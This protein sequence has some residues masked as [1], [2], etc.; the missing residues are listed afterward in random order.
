MGSLSYG[1]RWRAYSA[2]TSTNCLRWRMPP[3]THAG[4]SDRSRSPANPPTPRSLAGGSGGKAAGLGPA[5]AMA[6]KFCSSARLRA[7]TSSWLGR[8]SANSR[9]RHRCPGAAASASRPGHRCRLPTCHHADA[10]LARE[11][12]DGSLMLHACLQHLEDEV[13]R[14][15]PSGPNLRLFDNWLR[16]W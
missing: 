8:P 11:C 3:A 12:E 16:P 7:P 13:V 1:K 14:G 15:R 4:P 5:G 10:L 9:P 6:S 2:N